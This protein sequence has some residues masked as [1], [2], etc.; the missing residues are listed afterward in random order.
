M[1]LSSPF[2]DEKL[3][4]IEELAQGHIAGTLPDG[5]DSTAHI[6]SPGRA[7]SPSLHLGFHN[8]LSVSLAQCY[9]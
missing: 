1:L 3:E 8:H 5:S 6:P 2:T 4:V 7:A 9:Y